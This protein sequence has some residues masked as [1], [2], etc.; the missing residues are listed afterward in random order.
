MNWGQVLELLA[1]ACAEQGDE[2]RVLLVLPD[3]AF[4]VREVVGGVPPEDGGLLGFVVYR[5]DPELSNRTEATSLLVVR[6][7]Q[8][9]RLEVHGVDGVGEGVLGFGG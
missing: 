4:H 6:P 2:R 8:V 5:D 9:L 7:E 1:R 3:A